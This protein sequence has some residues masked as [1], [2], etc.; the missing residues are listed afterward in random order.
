[1]VRVGRFE[2]NIQHI[3][4]LPADKGA[5]VQRYAAFFIDI[6]PQHLSAGFFLVFHMHEF[7]PF[8]FT[9]RSGDFIH[10]GKDFFL[11][12]CGRFGSS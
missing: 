7:Q 10:P 1:M 5:V 2:M 9:Q 4:Q 11:A 6:Q 3:A 12:P 8:F